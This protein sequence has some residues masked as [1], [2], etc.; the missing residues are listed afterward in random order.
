MPTV[1]FSDIDDDARET[2]LDLARKIQELWW[3]RHCFKFQSGWVAASLFVNEDKSKSESCQ[4]SDAIQF[5][6][7]VIA[8]HNFHE[9]HMSIEGLSVTLFDH[10]WQH[11]LGY[12]SMK[13]T[14]QDRQDESED[15]DDEAN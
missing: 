1:N 12:L 6:R 13:Q 10:C 5:A 4:V 9:D 3:Q 8:S 14:E 2:L 11:Y 7:R 15:N